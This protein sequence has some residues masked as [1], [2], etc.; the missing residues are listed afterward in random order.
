MSFSQPLKYLYEP[1]AAVMKTMAFQAVCE[2]YN[3]FKLD[4]DAHLF[5]SNELIDFPGRAFE[6]NAVHAYKPKEIKKLYGSSERAVVTRNFREG[7]AQ[8][9][10]KY[11]LAE[12][13]T[14]YLFFTSV[15]GSYVVIEAVKVY[16]FP[17]TTDLLT[18]VDRL[19]FN[20]DRFVD[21]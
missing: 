7:V 12:S 18:T 6:I 10:T 5:T 17:M 11:K 1:N 15:A 2:Q 20:D 13:E 14:N 8:L 16:I 19:F 21:D 9:R 3:V 4:Q